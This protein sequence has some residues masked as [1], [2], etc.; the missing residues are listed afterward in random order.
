[1]AGRRFHPEEVAAAY[2]FL[3]ATPPFNKW[4]LPPSDEVG[5]AVT[6]HQDEFGAFVV[7]GEKITIRISA[8][9]QS[10]TFRLLEVLAHELIHMAQHVAKKSTKSSHNADFNARAKRVCALHGFDP[11]GF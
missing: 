1:M 2:D 10:H 6:D 8:N 5:F 11:K 4:K 7:D 3:A 9:F